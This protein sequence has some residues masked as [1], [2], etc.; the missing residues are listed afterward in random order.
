MTKKYL[1]LIK[2]FFNKG[3][4]TYLVFHVTSMCDSKCRMCFNWKNLNRMA[5][6]DELTLDE[7]EKTSKSFNK[8]FYVSIGGGEPFMRRDISDIVYVF[9]KNNNTRMFQIAT[10]CL[11]SLHTAEQVELILKKCKG[12]ILKITL[13]LDGIG[14]DHDYVRGVKG[15][16]EKFL[17][18]YELLNALK[19]KYEH[20]E[21]QVTTVY[22][23]Y[24]EE[25]AQDIYEWVKKNLNVD[26]HNFSYVRG[27]TK[28]ENAKDVSVKKYEKLIEYIEDEYRKRNFK[29]GLF[30]KLFTVFSM[31]T[32]RHV[33]RELKGRSRQF[34]CLGG[35]RLLQLG[36]YGEVFPCEYLPEKQ[37]GN[38]R[39]YDYDITKILKSEKTKAALKFISDKKCSCTWECAIKQDIVY[40]CRTWPI[41]VREMLRLR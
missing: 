4:P 31:L 35:R 8:L 40:D 10:N 7:I 3:M 23:K 9:Y 12:A 20:L 2:F 18:T 36:A 30:K 34:R 11:Q 26:I 28:E 29:R 37:L 32:R 6:Q 19:T 21:I 27:E 17:K 1:D 5:Q 24:T 16:F 33:I 13:S 15:N 39:D 22:S 41:V 25:K 38:L 14:E